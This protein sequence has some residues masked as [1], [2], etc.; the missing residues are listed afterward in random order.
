MDRKGKED[1]TIAS[2]ATPVGYSGIGIVRISGRR[3]RKIAAAV[4][5]PRQ[6]ARGKRVAF[7]S[8]KQIFGTVRTGSGVR[9]EAFLTYFAASRSYTCEDVVEISCH[10][11][12]VILD[13]LVKEIYRLGARAAEPGEFTFRAFRHGRIDLAQAEAVNELVHARNPEHARLAYDV[14]D[15]RISRQLRELGSDIADVHALCEAAIEFVDDVEGE[16]GGDEIV[17]R[18]RS[19]RGRLSALLEAGKKA[20]EIRKFVQVV[21][22]GLPNVGKSTL[23]NTLLGQDRAIVT[24]TPGTTRDL[25]R[26]TVRKDGVQLRLIDTAGLRE[27]EHGDIEKE[28]IRRARR[29]IRSADVV[30][31]L[32]DPGQPDSVRRLRRR[33]PSNTLLVVNKIDLYRDFE[34]CGKNAVLKISALKKQNIEAVWDSIAERAKRGLAAKGDITVLLNE[35]HEQ[36]IR[37]GLLGIGRAIRSAETG[38]LEVAVEE[39]KRA[40][41]EIGRIT[42]EEQEEVLDRIFRTFCIGK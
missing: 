16:I 18:L 10:G 7:E 12:P 15:G 41:R 2:I 31:E 29:V 38:Y 32:I 26:E 13:A 9:D 5:E 11:S 3:A 39:V 19:I 42:G 17:M 40:G 36:I 22:A 21:I 28:A 20:K 4:F 30:L 23:F 6:S 14:L 35:R 1:D 37:R 24:A 33:V 25:L 27:N 8:H 34:E